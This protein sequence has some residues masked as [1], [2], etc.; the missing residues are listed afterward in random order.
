MAKFMYIVIAVVG[1]V[2]SSQKLIVTF[3]SDASH[4]YKV[5]LLVALDLISGKLKVGFS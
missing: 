5:G 4:L 2:F 1:G 3:S